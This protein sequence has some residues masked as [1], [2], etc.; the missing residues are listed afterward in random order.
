MAVM[1]PVRCVQM[2]NVV[3]HIG[4]WCLC[5]AEDGWR[6]SGEVPWHFHTHAR[7]RSHTHTHRS[8]DDCGEEEDLDERHDLQS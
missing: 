5:L 2:G 8:S 7:A 3:V 4:L 1:I 6:W